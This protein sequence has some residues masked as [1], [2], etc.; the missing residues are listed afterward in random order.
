M[1][2]RYS[3]AQSSND[4]FDRM[5]RVPLVLQANGIQVETNALV[6]S[7]AMINVMP[8]DV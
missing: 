5:P 6:D 2:F 3:S 4:E 1:R 8:F 7:G